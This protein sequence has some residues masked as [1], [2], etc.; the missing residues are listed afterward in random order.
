VANPLIAVVAVSMAL[1]PLLMMINEKL[2]QPFIGTKEK[3]E[4]KPDIVDEENS[5]IIAGYGDFGSVIGRFLRANGIE[6]TVL[7]ADPNH[8]DIL[9]KLG[10]KVFY[11]DASRADLLAAAGADHIYRESLD[12][13]LRMGNKVLQLLGNRSF[14]SLRASH[15][16]RKKDEDSLR[17]LAGMRH[18]RKAKGKRS[19]M[20]EELVIPLGSLLRISISNN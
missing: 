7:D 1:T 15:F 14:K 8:V 2:I 12:T 9:R 20:K 3:E 19:K 4:Q 6:T 16:F 10:M 11:G 5:V 13:S 17:V 18:D